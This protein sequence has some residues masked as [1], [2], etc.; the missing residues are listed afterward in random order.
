[1]QFSLAAAAVAVL[2]AASTT[3]A[4]PIPAPDA[5][6]P[7]VLSSRNDPHE[8]DFRTFGA[9]GCSA[10]NQGIYTLT[11][12]NTDQCQPF[13]DPIGSVL[14]VDNLC[15]L[16]VYDDA[17]CS[18]ASKVLPTKACQDGTWKSYKLTC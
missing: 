6:A 9:P 4:G 14:V 8:A 3:M 18:Q 2:V 17:A 7:A 13:A 12:S 10:E 11:L 15:T 5:H 16:T 1:M